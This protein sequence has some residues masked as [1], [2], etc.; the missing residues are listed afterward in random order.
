MTLKEEQN[1]IMLLLK[2]KMHL[3]ANVPESFNVLVKELEGL[4]HSNSCR[5]IF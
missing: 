5:L 4:G 1:Y 3:Q 2:L